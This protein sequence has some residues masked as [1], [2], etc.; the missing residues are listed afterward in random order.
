[1]NLPLLQIFL[2][3]FLYLFDNFPL[4]DLD[5]QPSVAKFEPVGVSVES[6][7]C[8]FSRAGPFNVLKF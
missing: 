8:Y 6:K 7:L 4:L 2:H 5:P 3:F 1:M